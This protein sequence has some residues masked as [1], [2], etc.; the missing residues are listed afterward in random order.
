L[1]SG[2]GWESI[3]RPEDVGRGLGPLWS[4]LIAA[5]LIALTLFVAVALGMQEQAL[6]AAVESTA[7][8][9]MTLPPATATESVTPDTPVPPATATSLPEPTAET[10][11]PS[12][13]PSLTPSPTM[14]VVPSRTATFVPR[15]TAP[16]TC[17]QPPS[18]WYRY[19][20]QRGDNLYRLALE[21]GTLSPHIPALCLADASARGH[22][23]SNGRRDGQ[24]HTEPDWR[25]TDYS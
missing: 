3:N 2:D 24:S 25:G 12:P 5:A 14:P 6:V 21:T 8:S 7:T 13:V 20:V 4:G 22:Q 16:P 23:Y 9:T 19:F 10:P 11:S 1:G 15:R 18:W 17:L